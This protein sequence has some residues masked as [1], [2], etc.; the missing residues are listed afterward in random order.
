MKLAA[1]RERV[2]TENRERVW[3]DIESA[4]TAYRIRILPEQLERARARVAMLEKEAAALGM[5]DLL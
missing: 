3:R 4:R 1:I 2:A 5:N